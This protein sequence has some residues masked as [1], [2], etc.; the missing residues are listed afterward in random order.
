MSPL[1]RL[2][3]VPLLLVAATGAALTLVAPANGA[4]A[5]VD[6]DVIKVDRSMNGI[7]IHNRAWWVVKQMG[8]PRQVTRG[9]DDLGR[10]RILKYPDRFTV[11]ISHSIGTVTISTRSRQPRTTEGI[12][13][14]STLAQLRAE[15][16]VS[17]QQVPDDPSRQVCETQPPDLGESDTHTVFQLTNQVVRVVKL[18]ICDC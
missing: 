9:S 2:R 13:V 18:E 11:K 14:G 5:A 16:D 8:P 7:R 12:G 6:T 10:Y 1:A 15:Y 17:C 4:T 3:P